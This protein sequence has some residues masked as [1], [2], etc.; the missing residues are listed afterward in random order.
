MAKKTLRDERPEDPPVRPQ[1]YISV[2]IVMAMLVLMYMGLW[3][4]VLVLFIGLL[5]GNGLSWFAR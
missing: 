4:W 1:L 3:E 2:I 5:V